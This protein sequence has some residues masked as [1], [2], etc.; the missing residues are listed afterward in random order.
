MGLCALTVTASLLSRAQSASLDQFARDLQARKVKALVLGVYYDATPMLV[1]FGALQEHIMPHAR[2]LRI[3]E[4]TGKWEAVSL[5][6]YVGMSGRAAPR[7]GVSEIFAQSNQL[8]YRTDEGHWHHRLCHV[9]PRV[10]QSQKARMQG[11]VCFQN[12]HRGNQL[13]KSPP[14]AIAPALFTHA[15]LPVHAHA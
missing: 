2:F 12:L 8:S 14:P 3:N 13:C 6:R 1:A 4:G 7:F 11:A 10:V 5:E 15:P 9:P